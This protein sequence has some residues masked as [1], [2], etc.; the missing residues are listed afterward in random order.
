M[1]DR[2]TTQQEIRMHHISELSYESALLLETVTLRDT[3]AECWIECN[4]NSGETVRVIPDM[5]GRQGRLREVMVMNT[6]TGKN[7]KLYFEEVWHCSGF[8]TLNEARTDDAAR[9][10]IS[11]LPSSVIDWAVKRAK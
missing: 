8:W 1:T 5:T 4:K 9:E 7:Q 11:S 2:I 3:S 10:V 6:A